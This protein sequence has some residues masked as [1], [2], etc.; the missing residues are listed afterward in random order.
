MENVKIPKVTITVSITKIM[1]KIRFISDLSIYENVFI[2][3]YMSTLKHA[4]IQK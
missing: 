1:G 4:E 3:S 2:H